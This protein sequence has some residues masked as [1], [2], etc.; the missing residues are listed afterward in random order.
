MPLGLSS[1]TEAVALWHSPR[2][3]R[4]ALAIERLDGPGLESYTRR[5][6]R[7]RSW[8]VAVCASC[9]LACAGKQ[10]PSVSLQRSLGVCPS[11]TQFVPGSTYMDGDGGSHTVG[12]LCVD[13]T[14]VTA[15]AYVRCML[16]RR[17]TPP[18]TAAGCTWNMKS[19][20]SHP[21]NCVDHAQAV[22]YCARIGR[23]LPTEWEWAWV[24]RGASAFPGGKE[25][26][27]CDRVVMDNGCGHASTWP[28]GSRPAGRT[29]QGVDDI[30]G[31]VWEWTHSAPDDAN[32][33][34]RGGSWKSDRGEM[35]SRELRRESTKAKRDPGIGFR[36]V[37]RPT[38]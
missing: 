36:C 34:L 9:L 28:V 11:H 5:P 21:V 20:Q 25:A 2:R 31:N 4:A 33:V 30:L 38:L 7:I 6:M 14:E 15:A 16:A 12:D 17:C 24:A 22:A 23:R 32:A 35:R 8:G 10:E 3:A 26:P 27:N 13:T 29:P 18:D 19:T 37:T 1:N